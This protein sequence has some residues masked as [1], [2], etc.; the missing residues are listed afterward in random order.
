MNYIKQVSENEFIIN[1]YVKPNSK[2]QETVDPMA[3]D[4]FLVIFLRSAPHKNKANIELLKL[5]KKKL[6]NILHQ[7]QIISGHKNHLKRIKL[8]TIE[9]IKI[10]EIDELL[11]N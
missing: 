1:L 3:E 10:E 6:R 11:S 4:E 2:K 9:P 5:L 7:I 8:T